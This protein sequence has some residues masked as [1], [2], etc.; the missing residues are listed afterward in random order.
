MH[1]LL[2]K[3][4]QVNTEPATIIQPNPS[5]ERVNEYYD[6]DSECDDEECDNIRGYDSD[7]DHSYCD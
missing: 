6:I 5:G 2:M 7:N 3:R 1:E 4:G